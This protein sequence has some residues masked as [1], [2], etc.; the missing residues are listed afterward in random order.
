MERKQKRATLIFVFPYSVTSWDALRYGFEMLLAKDINVKVFDLSTLFSS[1]LNTNQKILNEKY[2]KKICSYQEFDEEVNRTVDHSIFIDCVNGING[3]Q[4][5]GRQIFRIFKKYDA[6]YFLIEIGSLPLLPNKENFKL[7]NKIKKAFNIQKLIKFLKWKLGKWVV[8][9]QYNYFSLYQLP[10]KIFVGNTEMVGY[11]LNK[12]RLS[13]SQI[14]S[15]HSF[16]YDRYLY[17]LRSGQAKLSD[18]KICVFLDQA[19]T[20]HR[21]FDG[22]AGFR[23]ITEQNYLK[24]MNQLFDKIESTTKL[25]IVIAASPR[26][27]PDELSRIF[28]NRT[29]IRDKTLELVAQSSLVL[30]HNS[31][32]VSFAVLFDKPIL[33][34]KTSEMLNS[35]GFNNFIDNMANALGLKPIC[36][37]HKNEMET[38]SLTNYGNWK[39]NYTEYK[40]KYVKTK[41]LADKTTWE[42]V[43]ENL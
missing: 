35:Y 42:I 34:L 29:V 28:G 19:L 1:R 37:D 7:I 17:Y 11:Y 36:I 3:F 39:R 41:G 33:I 8:N 24:S 21:D 18:S 40:H 26:A 10:K 23:P 16:D 12:Y 25:K 6:T 15:I 5:K 27:N 13:P 4:W 32:A 14:V 43:V 22:P 20:H 9:F 30:M 31:T 2:I 38:L